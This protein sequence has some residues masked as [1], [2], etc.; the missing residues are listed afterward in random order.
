MRDEPRIGLVAPLPPQVGGVASFAE[1]LL[2]HQDTIGVRFEAFDLWK[3]PDDEVGGRLTPRA[4]VRQARL[5]G[6]FARWSLTAPPVIHYCLSYTPTGLTR[7]LAFLSVLRLAGRKTI[8]HVHGFAVDVSRVRSLGLNQLRRLTRERVVAT[9]RGGE[10]LAR[11]GIGSRC[12]PNPLRF[13]PRNS[14][15]ATAGDGFRLLLVGTTGKSKGGPDLV[16]ALARLRATGLDATL[17]V[18][19][20]EE[21]RGDAASLRALAQFRG[22]SSALDLA[23]LVDRERM[24]DE[25]ERADVVVLPS[26]REGLPMALLEAMAFGRAVVATRVGGVPDLVEDGVTGVLVAPGDVDGLTAALQELAADPDRRTR[27]GAAARE[28]VAAIA[29]PD[30]IARSWRELYEEIAAA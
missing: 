25:Y 29:A 1:W 26:R 5:L 23:G 14:G 24:P 2:E 11:L 4:M 27:M 17:R 6:R 3:R 20:R 18:V 28:R 21:R 19:G 8:G 22:V 13:E 30:A 7:D 12:I 15:R 9:P 10:V 16:E